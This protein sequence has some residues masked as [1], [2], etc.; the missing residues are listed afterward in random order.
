M[1]T[2][3]LLTLVLVFVLAS[4]ELIS[5]VG[6]EENN[7]RVSAA[8]GGGGL[9]SIDL[10]TF[11]PLPYSN[12]PNMICKPVWNTFLLRVSFISLDAFLLTCKYRVMHP[13]LTQ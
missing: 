5:V 6:A 12:M 4:W 2:S 13:V 11:L 9:C 3:V 7:N 10:S 1:I 8:G